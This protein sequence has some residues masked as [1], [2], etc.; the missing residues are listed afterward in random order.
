LPTYSCTTHCVE[1]LPISH[2]AEVIYVPHTGGDYSFEQVPLTFIPKGNYVVTSPSFFM[3]YNMRLWIFLDDGTGPEKMWATLN[4]DREKYG[5]EDSSVLLTLQITDEKTGTFMQADS[6]H[7]T[8]FLPDHTEK[9]VLTEDWS[10]NEQEQYYE[11]VWNFQNDAQV[12]CDPKEGFYAAEAWVK[13]RYYQDEHVVTGF[14]V[15]YHITIDATLDRSP[16]VYELGDPVEVTVTI[17]DESG[18]TV[19]GDLSI[20]LIQ[21][22]GQ[23][24][25][26]E[27]VHTNEVYTLSFRPTQEGLH[28]LDI[29]LKDDVKCYL[30]EA[31]TH[32]LVSTCEE[33]LTDITLS[34]PIVNEV[35]T[36]E[37]V[38][39]DPQGNPLSGVEIESELHTP[40]GSLTLSWTEFADG[41]YSTEF[42]PT[43]TGFYQI[44]GH[45]SVLRDTCY[46]GFF[47]A[48]CTV[49]EKRM[50]DLLI[51]NEDISVDPEPELGDMVTISVTAHN[52]GN[53]DAED[54]WV[55]ILINDRVVY[56]EFFPVLPAGASYTLDYEWL[57]IHSG[58]YIIQ[59]FADAPESMI[60]EGIV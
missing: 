50:P 53:K 14:S 56:W 24:V 52:I 4:T 11:Y 32:F 45:F 16:P 58:A 38:I 18:E 35:I 20:E 23:P 51:S 47:E 12:M 25:E 49:T 7:S 6:I 40:E 48:A 10:W 46:R 44:C 19:T 42:T 26:V 22:A 36:A 33:A 27:W 9:T 30:E 31:H 21:P 5:R 43:Q 3:H 59:A 34:E 2:K 15:C 57:I 37:L 1:N 54:F 55:V 13:K 41:I 28:S 39:T 8:I 60:P 17:L 29:S